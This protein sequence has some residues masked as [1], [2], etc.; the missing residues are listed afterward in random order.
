MRKK[1]EKY[2]VSWLKEEIQRQECFVYKNSERIITSIVHSVKAEL[3]QCLGGQVY[4]H[5]KKTNDI[6]LNKETGIVQFWAV[7]EVVSKN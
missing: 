7:V 2:I 1:T 6:T 3:S 5:T 4:C